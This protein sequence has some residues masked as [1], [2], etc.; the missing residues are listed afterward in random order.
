[1]KK[2]KPK[3]SISKNKISVDS[4]STRVNK[5]PKKYSKPQLKQLEKVKIQLWGDEDSG[6]FQ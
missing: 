3:N 4:K 1:M 6:N 2:Q 5:S